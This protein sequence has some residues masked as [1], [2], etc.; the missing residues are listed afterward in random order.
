MAPGHGTAVVAGFSTAVVGEP[1]G[2]ILGVAGS[3]TLDREV[4]GREVDGRIRVVGDRDRLVAGSGGRQATVVHRLDGPGPRDD[5]AAFADLLDGVGVAQR[6]V[7]VVVAIVGGGEGGRPGRRRCGVRVAV[8]IGRQIHVRRAGDGHLRSGLVDEGHHLVIGRALVSAVV[9]GLV[10]VEELTGAAAAHL[11][12]G[13]E[14]HLGAT[15]DVAGGRLVD[16]VGTVGLTGHLRN[17]SRGERRGGRVLDREGQRDG[18]AV[19][20]IVGSGED[21]VHR[22]GRT[23]QVAQVTVFIVVAPRHRTAIVRGGG[24]SLASQPVGKLGRIAFS[25]ALGGVVLSTGDDRRHQ[26]DH[27]D[28]L[29]VR[30]LV[31]GAILRNPRPVHFVAARALHIIL[32]RLAVIGHGRAL[33]I[34]VL[35]V[36]RRRHG[37]HLGQAVG[38]GHGL[39]FRSVVKRRIRGVIAADHLLYR[40]G[41]A[42][43]GVDGRIDERHTG[44]VLLTRIHDLG[45][46][47]QIEQ[48]V[49]LGTL[50]LLSVEGSLIAEPA[51]CTIVAV[52]VVGHFSDLEAEVLARGSVVD[53]QQGSIEVSLAEEVAQTGIQDVD[54]P[55]VRDVGRG[56]ATH[57]VL[58]TTAPIGTGHSLIVDDLDVQDGVRVVDVGHLSGDLGYPVL[59]LGQGQ[60]LGSRREIPIVVGIPI[61][62]EEHD[63]AILTR[64]ECRGGIAGVGGH[65]LL[66][67]DAGHVSAVGAYSFVAGGGQVAEAFDRIVAQVSIECDGVI[68]LSVGGPPGGEQTNEGKLGP[69]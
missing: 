21:H 51:A 57:V 25:I 49:A 22:A 55:G 33:G 58:E 63:G 32:G 42:A 64:A 34:A 11:V 48:D 46:A 30:G 66:S 23:A 54:G 3:V 17:R 40:Q 9:H 61:H 18:A 36:V 4:G 68:T 12:D 27:R 28:G 8:R 19:A 52:A 65:T 39:V 14:H 45:R 15:A 31:A 2:E 16:A 24:P 60:S 67:E 1:I 10:G 47:L 38:T 37:G 6:V 5:V 50:N 44:L 62:I 59:E 26:I 53:G 20:A 29:G 35:T 7:E 43:V 56:H 13:D 69:E 41:I